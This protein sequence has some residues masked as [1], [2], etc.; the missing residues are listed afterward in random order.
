VDRWFAVYDRYMRPLG[1]PIAN[2]V[3][4]V[5]QNIAVWNQ[6]AL[7]T[8]EGRAQMSDMGSSPSASQSAAGLALQ[9]GSITA[10]QAEGI[11]TSM[12]LGGRIDLM[13]P[14][15]IKP[16]VPSPDRGP[17][18]AGSPPIYAQSLPHHAPVHPPA[19][20]GSPPIPDTWNAQYDSPPRR[21]GPEYGEMRGGMPEIYE[22]AWDKPLGHQQR[23]SEDWNVAGSY[24]HIP[25]VVK[26]DKWYAGAADGKPDY[27]K[28][29]TVFPWEQKQRQPPSR[30]FPA[31]DPP[32][33][34]AAATPVLRLQLPSPPAPEDIRLPPSTATS[35][36]TGQNA[37]PVSFHQAMAQY[38]NAWDIPSIQNYASR[39]AGPRERKA[40]AKGMQT[41]ALERENP[42]GVLLAGTDDRQQKGKSPPTR[43][44]SK[45][46]RRSNEAATTEARSEGSRDGDDEETTSGSDGEQEEE[47]Y[48]IVRRGTGRPAHSRTGS[49]L[50]STGTSPAAYSPDLGQKSG[51]KQYTA[52]SVQT[53][54][55][56]MQDQV[57]QTPPEER[58]AS[59][60]STA[61]ATGPSS[62]KSGK[63]DTS[64]RVAS[65]DIPLRPKHVRQS[66]EETVT[67]AS[68][69][70]PR[71]NTTRLP[72]E[73]S[74]SS[75]PSS[76]SRPK[77]TSRIFDPST[78]IDVS[79]LS[80]LVLYRTSNT[81]SLA[82]RNAG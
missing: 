25:D 61:G 6:P 7:S 74:T 33:P 55:V 26:E 24:P 62:W 20:Q 41:P 2:P 17:S 43:P 34:Q 14:Q 47:R 15:P 50:S 40:L 28:V 1:Q 10:G 31:S 77:P 60:P 12:P 22:N 9:G 63:G 53:D 65:S 16:S 37:R 64:P 71:T 19:R 81:E 23:Q 49:K 21:S 45:R 32:P 69:N 72:G 8:A 52:R 39:L 11:Y 56:P 75:S 18:L 80:S 30:H 46:N 5:P 79:T 78:S 27:S 48:P 82:F 58:A 51:P 68:Y 44:V 38:T 67:H 29:E 3:F 70:S 13:R 54:P 66:S 4:S 36:F 76:D 59:I 35:P 42:L 73:D 57:V